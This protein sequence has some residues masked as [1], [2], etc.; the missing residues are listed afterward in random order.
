M[1]LPQAAGPIIPVPAHPLC[2]R[3]GWRGDPPFP[4]AYCSIGWA[5]AKGH[6]S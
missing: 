6:S 1:N 5:G 3:G 2:R 4:A